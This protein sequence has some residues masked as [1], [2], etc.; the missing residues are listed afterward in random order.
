MGILK[1]WKEQRKARAKKY[2]EIYVLAKQIWNT[3]LAIFLGY[4]D[5]EGIAHVLG[6]ATR[7]LRILEEEEQGKFPLWFRQT[8][9]T[10]GMAKRAAWAE[11][12]I[13]SIHEEARHSDRKRSSTRIGKL[14]VYKWSQESDDKKGNLIWIWACGNAVLMWHKRN[15]MMRVRKDALDMLTHVLIFKMLCWWYFDFSIP[16]PIPWVDNDTHYAKIRAEKDET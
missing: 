3:P 13:R 1:Q 12:F 15:N 4:V 9:Q 16:N 11:N 2:P 6:C 5:L 14:M 8:R 7:L 10:R